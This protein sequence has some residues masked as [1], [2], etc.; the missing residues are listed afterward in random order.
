MLITNLN[1]IILTFGNLFCAEYNTP[2]KNIPYTVEKIYCSLKYY[3]ISKN[4]YQIHDQHHRKPL[5]TGFQENLSRGDITHKYPKKMMISDW[6]VRPDFCLNRY[7]R[8]RPFYL[9]FGPDIF[10]PKFIFSQHIFCKMQKK[11]SKVSGNRPSRSMMRASK[12]LVSLPLLKHD[13]KY[14]VYISV[15][16][17]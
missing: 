9:F 15:S 8:T 12:S 3:K 7:D 6:I 17:I 10:L 14:Y 2:K 4:R 16:D 5:Y 1:D 11:G 13:I